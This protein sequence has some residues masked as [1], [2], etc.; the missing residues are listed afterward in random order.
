M[1][2]VQ[3]PD[4]MLQDGLFFCQFLHQVD[5]FVGI[6]PLVVVPG[7]DL[8]KVVVKGDAGFCI[9]DGGAGITDKVL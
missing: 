9:E 5:E 6:A 4:R 1:P 7:N 3:A 8:H 2:Q